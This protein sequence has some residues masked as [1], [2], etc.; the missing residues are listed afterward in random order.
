MFNFLSIISSYLGYINVNVKLKNR[1]YTVLGALGNLYLLYVALR[2]FANG[3]YLRGFLFILAFAVAAYFSYLNILY[4]FTKDKKSRYDIS[5]VIERWLHIAPPEAAEEGKMRRSTGIQPGYIQTN[6]LFDDDQEF[7]PAV[8]TASSRERAN[9]QQVVN[10]LERKGY[11]QLDYDGKSNQEI[12]RSGKRQAA[13]SA[14]VTL[15][16]YE[17]VQTGKYLEVYG[18]VNQMERLPLGRVKTV[19]LLPAVEAMER[20]H[21]Y[22]ASAAIIKGPYKFA[23]RSDV[24]VQARDFDLDIKVAYRERGSQR[25]HVTTFGSENEEPHSLHRTQAQE[26]E[27]EEQA[28]QRAFRRSSEAGN[29]PPLRRR[30]AQQKHSGFRDFWK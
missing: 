20:Y 18:G 10:D 28:S 30:Q 21:L 3:F 15:P 16:Y 14:P 23:G 22:L 6:G 11:L 4:Y 9:I 7:L 8:I 19:G 1:I 26:M 12:Y 2:F 27:A 13:L 5:P 25:Q 24:I 17:L 29:E